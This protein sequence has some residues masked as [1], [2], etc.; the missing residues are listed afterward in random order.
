MKIGIRIRIFQGHELFLPSFP[1]ESSVYDLKNAISSLKGISLDQMQLTLPKSQHNLSDFLPLKNI[2]HILT[3]NIASFDLRLF[4]RLISVRIIRVERDRSPLTLKIYPCSSVRKLKERI[5]ILTQIPI[6][7]QT[8][9]YNNIILDNENKLLLDYGIKE[10][11]EDL[12]NLSSIEESNITT[13]SR[14]FEI[15]L[16]VRRVLAKPGKLN[17]GI[18]F[19]FN[20]IKNVK[21]SDWKATAPWYRA[22]SDGL[23]WI[24]YCRNQEC[25]INN[26]VFIINRGYGHYYLHSEIKHI[27]CPICMQRKSEIKNIGFVNCAWQYKGTLKSKKDSR[28]S[29]DGKTYDNKFY[30]FKEADYMNIWETLELLAKKMEKSPLIIK[31][32]NVTEENEESDRK[33]TEKIKNEMVCGKG[34]TC[35]LL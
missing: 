8:L 5:Q 12:L 29:G 26:Q 17:L 22:V 21:K 7:E 35:N 27:V 2:P 16:N 30:T 1:I 13:T 9:T 19:S 33:N 31:N 15:F 11:T 3:K 4:N 24:C 10:G 25:T 18:D 28:I 6:H 34:E 14:P 20:S 23:S 32:V